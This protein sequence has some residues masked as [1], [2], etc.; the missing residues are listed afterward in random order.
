MISSE[1][2]EII[3][4]ENPDLC[5]TRQC[6]LLKIS[7]S[8]ICY[9]P[10]GFDQATLDLMHEIDWTFTKHPFFGSCQIAASL[11]Q[12]GFSTGRHRVR[13]L[14]GIM[15][16]QAIYKGPNTSKN[17]RRHMFWPYML[18]KLAITRPNQ[19]W[20]SDISYIPVKNGLLY[21]VAIMDWATRKVWSWRLSNTLDANFCP[22]AWEEAIAK[23]GTPEIMK[24]DQ[25]S[26][27]TGADWI[28]TLTEAEI[29]I[30]W[31]CLAISIATR[32]GA[33]GVILWSVIIGLLFS[34]IC[35]KP[36]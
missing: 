15:G 24:T 18:R 5:L 8:S 10:V 1:R 6:K 20:C 9:T 36:L 29:K 2:R 3:C 34:V 11:P 13:R 32:T 30:S 28:K 4:K 25:R 21:L 27:Y 16:F 7:R 35:T 14:M 26:Q 19:V 12:S 23:Y 31:R 33:S 17:H 22:A